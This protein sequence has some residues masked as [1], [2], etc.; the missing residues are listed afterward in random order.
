MT[1]VVNISEAQTHLKGLLALAKKGDEIII[2]E[3]G[4]MLGK[5]TSSET[6]NTVSV[7][8]PGL[9][10]GMFTMSEDFDE[11]LPDDFWGLDD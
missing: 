2:E 9:G 8:K 1:K 5:I 6:Q 10:K 7:R 11:E 3:N 4:Q